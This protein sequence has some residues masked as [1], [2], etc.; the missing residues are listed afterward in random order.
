MAFRINH[1]PSPRRRTCAWTNCGYI[2]DAVRFST[3]SKWLKS[4]ASG[5]LVALVLLLN[6]L[7]AS[8]QL[9]EIFHTDHSKADHLCAVTMFAHGQMD[10]A[11]AAVTAGLPSAGFDFSP[12]PPV[13]V[14]SL[15]AETLPPGRA[16]PVS[17]CNS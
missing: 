11:D 3:T 2:P 14:F 15:A 16:P 17:S 5:L 6:A 4:P 13:M 7:A 1:R 8:P 12:P 9:H 10:A